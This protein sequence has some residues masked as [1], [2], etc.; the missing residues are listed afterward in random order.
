MMANSV[1]NHLGKRIL[2]INFPSLG[3]TLAGENIKFIFREVCVLF[4]HF[5]SLCQFILLPPF[6]LMIRRKSMMQLSSL[7]SV[8]RFLSRE[9][10]G[11]TKSTCY[12]LKLNDMMV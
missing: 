2:L 4:N 9:N 12:S 5:L 6:L 10:M 8:N 3:T 7:M 1:A 11:T